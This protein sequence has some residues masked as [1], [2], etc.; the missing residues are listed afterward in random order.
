MIG[1]RLSSSFVP[2]HLVLKAEIVEGCLNR[3]SRNNSLTSC[4]SQN[5]SVPTAASCSKSLLALTRAQSVTITDGR[6]MQAAEAITPNREGAQTL[7]PVPL[8][9]CPE[10]APNRDLV[11]IVDREDA[12]SPAIFMFFQQVRVQVQH[13]YILDMLHSTVEIACPNTHVEC[14]GAVR[15]SCG[16]K[17]AS[18]VWACLG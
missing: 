7:P 15:C 17:A 5:L 2:S 14:K 10:M 4:L 16:K 12:G 11:D 1:K 6:C 9:A 18:T 8:V 13:A 3:S